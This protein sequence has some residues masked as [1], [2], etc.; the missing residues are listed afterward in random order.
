M[1]NQSLHTCNAVDALASSVDLAVLMSDSTAG[2]VI[3]KL[4]MAI[5]VIDDH[6]SSVGM[7]LSFKPN[8][9]AGMLNLVGKH[10]ILI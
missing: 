10:Q 1:D 2:G 8:K 9:T 7:E 5:A 4:T 3:G 6:I